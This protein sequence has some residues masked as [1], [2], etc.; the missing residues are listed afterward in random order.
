MQTIAMRIHRHDRRET[1]HTQM[2][3]GFGTPNSSRFT[4]STSARTA[5]NTAPRPDRIQI[6]RPKLLKRRRR[7]RP[8]PPL[9]ITARTP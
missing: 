5:H 1:I 2:P 6:N 9:P 4:S 8:I 3:H 7:L